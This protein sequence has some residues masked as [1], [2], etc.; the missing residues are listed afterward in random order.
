MYIKHNLQIEKDLPNCSRAVNTQASHDYEIP[1]GSTI[2]GNII[3]QVPWYEVQSFSCFLCIQEVEHVGPGQMSEVPLNHCHRSRWSPEK[4]E[5]LH[6]T[7]K[8]TQCRIR[9]NYLRVV[10]NYPIDETGTDQ[11][12]QIIVTFQ[13]Q[14]HRALWRCNLTYQV[15]QHLPNQRKFCSTYKFSG[16]NPEGISFQ[17]PIYWAYVTV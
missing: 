7:I 15:L 14:V 9:A 6:P 13:Y 16:L 11:V 3:K 10:N 12:K 17:Y 5:K 1:L 2:Q 8:E 4:A